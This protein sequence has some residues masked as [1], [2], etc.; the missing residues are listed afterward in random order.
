MIF[1]TR[2]LLEV[3]HPDWTQVNANRHQAC[4]LLEVIAQVL[5]GVNDRIFGNLI[6]TY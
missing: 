3:L 1:A 4:L 2:V 5:C 6:I